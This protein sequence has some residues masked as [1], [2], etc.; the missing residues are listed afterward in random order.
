MTTK[1]LE[2]R[3]F[4]RVTL[5]TPFQPCRSCAVYRYWNYWISPDTHYTV[6]TC[7]ACGELHRIDEHTV[8]RYPVTKERAA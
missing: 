3:G 8:Q 4:R 6:I 5:P 1:D 2:A 7:D